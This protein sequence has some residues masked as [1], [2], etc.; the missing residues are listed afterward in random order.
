M[1]MRTIKRG[2]VGDVI[3]VARIKKG[4]TQIE[5]SEK[6]GYGANTMGSI[7][8]GIESG[9]RLPP[10]DKI[11]ALSQILDVPIDDLVP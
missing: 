11:R 7:I 1:A 9:R 2:S 5:L 6:L 4:M 3:R 8:R 10:L